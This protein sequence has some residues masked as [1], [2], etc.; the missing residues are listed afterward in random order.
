MT[1]YW[2]VEET[3]KPRASQSKKK[4]WVGRLGDT[5]DSWDGEAF[6][7]SAREAR[8]EDQNQNCTSQVMTAVE[9]PVTPTKPDAGEVGDN[10]SALHG[11]SA[12]SDG[13]RRNSDSRESPD[14]LQGDK[15]VGDSWRLR[16]GRDRR[17]SPSNIWP[18][19]FSPAISKDNKSGGRQ[20]DHSNKKRQLKFPIQL[21]RFDTTFTQQ[22]LQLIV[23][24]EDANFSVIPPTESAGREKLN[25]ARV[26]SILYSGDTGNTKIRLQLPKSQGSPNYVD[27]Q[28]TNDKDTR[29]FHSIVKNL[30][31][32]KTVEKEK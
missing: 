22:P 5:D 3:V 6:T 9:I 23:D 30:S 29:R 13:Q 4:G 18:T 20:G 19:E 12:K 31:S 21:V 10:G 7:R 27:I 17:A 2:N 25:I 15:T 11:K 28:F 16:A 1:E 32:A 24:R 26:I 14:A 8:S